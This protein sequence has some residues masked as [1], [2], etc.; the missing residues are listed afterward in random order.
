MPVAADGR[1]RV[2]GVPDLAIAALVAGQSAA[3]HR[4]VVHV[5]DRPGPRT[6]GDTA[7]GA[8]WGASFPL[9][10]AAA[11]APGED[12][13]AWWAASTQPTRWVRS[14]GAL[15]F[16]LVL[17]PWIGTRRRGARAHPAGG[18]GRALMLA[19]YGLAH[20]S[21]AASSGAG[22]RRGRRRRVLS[23]SAFR[24]A[25]GMLIAYRAPHHDLRQPRRRFCYWGEG[26]NSSIAISQW[27][28]GAIQFHV[29]GKVE[30]STEPYDMRL[31]RMLGHM[32]ALLHP[33]PAVG[34]DC[35]IR[36]GSHGGNFRGASG[37]AAHRDLRDGAA[38]PA[39]R[40]AA[41][42]ATRTST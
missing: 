12:P 17:I 27:D 35:G 20:R 26:I 33:Q 30:A 10:L 32:P 3:G 19:P 11:A 5:S 39:H 28:D 24:P 13:D 7:G 38:D 25:P 23:A 9:A 21:T 18:R 8:V 40:H 14:S 34:A 22:R 2:D 1:H 42:S 36:R 6:L 37:G 41:I 4:A 31:Q 16:S 29:S 15:G